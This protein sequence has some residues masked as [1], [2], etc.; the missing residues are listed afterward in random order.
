MRGPIVYCLESEDNPGGIQNV[1]VSPAAPF[2]AEFKSNVLGGV[3]VLHGQVHAAIANGNQPLITSAE[4]TAIPY[5]ANANRAHSAM[6]VW[7]PASADKAVPASVASRSRASASHCGNLDSVDAI[8]D[9]IV[10]LKS[11]D[12]S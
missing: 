7:L 1:I 3:V 12:T 11:S 8:K 9:G 6:R 2:Q 4:V 5:Y 10:P